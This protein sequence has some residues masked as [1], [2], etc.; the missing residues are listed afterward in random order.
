MNDELNFKELALHDDLT[1]LKNT[2]AL[3]EDCESKN[4]SDIH[5]MYIDLA[6]FKKINQILGYDAGDDILR[7]I[8]EGLVKF[9][10]SS[11]V[12]RIGGD[13]FILLTEQ[14]P[15]C[16]PE[17][18]K[19]LFRHPFKHNDIQF[20]INANIAILDYGEFLDNTIKDILML[21]DFAINT[22]KK[23]NVSDI[24][25]VHKEIQM[26][27]LE[28]REI[29]KHIFDGVKRDKFFPLFRPFIDTF[30]DELVGFET[31][32]RWT[33][34]E[35]TVGPKQFLPIAMYTGLIFDI[36][37]KMYKETCQFL[38][39][40]KSSKNIKLNNMFKAAVNFTSQT[41]SRIDPMHLLEIL[42]DNNLKANEIIIELHEEFI[43]EDLVQRKIK[44]LKELGFYIILDGY[45][46]KN[47]TIYYLADTGVDAIKLDEKLLMKIDEDQ[48]YKKM[49]SVYKFM[50][51]LAK[52]VDVRVI[53]DGIKNSIDAELVKEL[54]INIGT[55]PYYSEPITK[56]DFIDKYFN[57]RI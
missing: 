22:T 24:I 41:L 7:N 15:S 1:G 2:R 23:T 8:S 35:K 9:C 32:S 25:E 53:S 5:F 19:Q 51:D 30:T 48:E 34:F 39:E 29:E 37:C 4:L 6:R 47:S 3:Y 42:V 20:V 17:A 46:T 16:E 57:G 13:K 31:V 12:Y 54:D 40:L 38:N 18:L 14:Q 27:F 50:A 33:F 44:I 45:S 36:E 55:G 49:H 10:E 52:K 56:N 26:N 28:K 11:E 43:E 21:F